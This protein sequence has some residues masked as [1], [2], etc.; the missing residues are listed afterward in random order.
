MK[1]TI[2]ICDKCL[3]ASCWLGVFMCWESDVAGTVEK[4]V[5]ELQKLNLEHPDWWDKNK[6]KDFSIFSGIVNR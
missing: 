4:T 5:E 3:K 2:T 1:N 6:V